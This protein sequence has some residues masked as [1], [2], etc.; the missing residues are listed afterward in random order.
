[1][2]G[3]LNIKLGSSGGG[4]SSTWGAI[5]GTLSNQTDL[6][7]ALGNKQPLSANLTA[8]SLV[9]AGASNGGSIQLSTGAIDGG[10]N[11]GTAGTLSLAGGD[12]FDD[13][14]SYNGGNAGILSLNG[15]AGVSG[16]NGG[17]GGNITSSAN[18]RYSGGSLTLNATSSNSG[19][20]INTTAGGNLFM[21]AGNLTGPATSGTIFTREGGTMTGTLVLPAG[22]PSTPSLT[23]GDSTTGI[24]KVTTNAISFASNGAE[25]FRVQATVVNS[26]VD[27]NI[28]S[29]VSI[30]SNSDVFLGRRSAAWWGLGIASA[31]PIEQTLS[32]CDGST[33]NVTGGI[34]NISA[35]RGTGTGISGVLNF[36]SHAAAASGSTVN[37]TPVN[38]LSIIRPGVIRITDIPTSSAGL[39]TGDVYSNAGILTIV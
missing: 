22:S 4:G 9:D 28:S 2:T 25:R 31:T 14:T 39:S 23:L 13:G 32:G 1:M 29:S 26:F 18:G 15:A 35:G 5:T 37:A 8:L 10:G 6:D 24:Y 7:T 11:G 33:S 38:V 34:L 27:F 16:Y 12:G 21:G 17:S 3:S 30:S 20:S 19:G 36:R